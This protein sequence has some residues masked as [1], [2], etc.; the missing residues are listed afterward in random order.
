MCLR[1]VGKTSVRVQG[2]GV[3]YSSLGATSRR[4]DTGGAAGASWHKSAELA[5]S[6]TIS[7][8]VGH[9]MM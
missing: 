1:Q 4:A 6:R 9:G 5:S 8:A 7:G 2:V 3:A